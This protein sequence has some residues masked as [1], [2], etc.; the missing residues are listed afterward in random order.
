MKILGVYN[1][2]G[3]NGVWLIDVLI[4]PYGSDIDFGDVTQRRSNSDRD[5]WQ[6]AYDER[7]VEY[8]NEGTRWAFFFH[9]LDFDKALET[10]YGSITLPAPIEAPEEL[11][12]IVYEAPC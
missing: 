8:S 12:T 4:P 1:V 2:K 6:V 5:T 7:I 3:K 10:P 9:D 11:C